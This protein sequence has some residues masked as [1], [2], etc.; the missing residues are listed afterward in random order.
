MINI[1]KS[2]A[3]EADVAVRIIG[4]RGG[5]KIHETLISNQE[6]RRMRKEAGYY[7]I[8]PENRSTPPEDS[9][10]SAAWEFTSDLEPLSEGETD[11]FLAEN[12]M[13]LED[14]PVFDL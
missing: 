12:K 1:A 5:E 14:T 7:I 2:L 8:K 3:K 10:V 4:M 11:H 6:A 9:E 13:T